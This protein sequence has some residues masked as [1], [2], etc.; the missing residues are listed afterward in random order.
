MHDLVDTGNG[1]EDVRHLALDVGARGMGLEDEIV[2]PEQLD[3]AAYLV[4]DRDAGTERD[5]L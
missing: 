4:A 3:D 1:G 2:F 5:D